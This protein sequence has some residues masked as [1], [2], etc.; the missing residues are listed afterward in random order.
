MLSHKP[1][2]MLRGHAGAGSSLWQSPAWLQRDAEPSVS[3]A[4]VGQTPRP[5]TLLGFNLRQDIL[6]KR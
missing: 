3:H 4:G 6:Q 2:T 1:S 5:L